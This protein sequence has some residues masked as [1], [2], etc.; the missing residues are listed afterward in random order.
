MMTT[1]TA[2]ALF[3]PCLVLQNVLKLTRVTKKFF[4]AAHVKSGSS[5]N[6]QTSF[7]PLCL[8]FPSPSLLSKLWAPGGSE[9]G[10]ALVNAKYGRIGA[11]GSWEESVSVHWTQLSFSSLAAME[12]K[13]MEGRSF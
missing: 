1:T 13:R 3:S 5:G 10:Q 7:S 8:P 11:Q 6:Q 12:G 2:F 4:K 9:L